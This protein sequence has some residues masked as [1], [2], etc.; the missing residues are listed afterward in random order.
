MTG[1]AIIGTGSIAGRTS[2]SCRSAFYNRESMQA[3]MPRFHRKTKSVDNFTDNTITLGR[4][5]G[6]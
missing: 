1:V 4:D 2:T 5:P 6:K 3:A